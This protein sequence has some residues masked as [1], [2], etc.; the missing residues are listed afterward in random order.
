[1]VKSFFV[2]CFTIEALAMDGSWLLRAT[3]SYTPRHSV[4][5]GF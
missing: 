3:R 5:N 4:V 1:M 2:A